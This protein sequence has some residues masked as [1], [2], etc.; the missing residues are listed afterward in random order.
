MERDKRLIRLEVD[1]NVRKM[2]RIEFGLGDIVDL[3]GFYSNFV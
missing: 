2:F 3:C 1:M